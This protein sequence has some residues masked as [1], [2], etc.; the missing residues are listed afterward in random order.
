MVSPRFISLHP[1]HD[2]VGR[3]GTQNHFSTQPP[4]HLQHFSLDRT[5]MPR[6]DISGQKW[7]K[8]QVFFSK[9]KIH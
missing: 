4:P 8:V 6:R 2:L 7:R 3:K 5:Y 9:D 1:G